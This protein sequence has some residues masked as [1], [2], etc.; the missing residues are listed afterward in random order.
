MFFTGFDNN[1]HH[2]Y[3]NP[4]KGPGTGIIAD[5]WTSDGQAAG[6]LATLLTV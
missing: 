6:P 5:Q 3:W 4:G 1:V 2:V